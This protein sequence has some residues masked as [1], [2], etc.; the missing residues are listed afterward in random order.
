MKGLAEPFLR[1]DSLCVL[2][3]LNSQIQ[4]LHY[5]TKPLCLEVKPSWP[6]RTIE[7]NGGYE[8]L[9]GGRH[10]T[11][12]AELAFV[13]EVCPLG[14]PSKKSGARR[15]FEVAGKASTVASLHVTHEGET[16]KLASWRMEF[17]DDVSPG[18]HFHAQ[19]PDTLRSGSETDAPLKELRMWPSWLP[20]PRLP[21]PA[22]TPMLAL[23]YVLAEVFQDQWPARLKSDPH[24][25]GK[26]RDL[27]RRRLSAYFRWQQK[28]S[29]SEDV[30][31]PL[32]A[33][34]NAKPSPDMFLN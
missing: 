22:F 9:E 15:L 26:W 11:L 23:E 6:I 13:W 3:H 33:V 5:G 7:C 24:G 17:G 19:I 18:A 25:I 32:I 1:P 27:Q 14:Q 20:V 34:K 4:T 21:I 8:R 28:I 16:S 2:D 10:K 12:H 29:N 30:L 31:T